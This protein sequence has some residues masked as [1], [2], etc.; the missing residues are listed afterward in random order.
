MQLRITLNKCTD[1]LVMPQ[2]RCTRYNADL[3]GDFFLLKQMQER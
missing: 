3:N 1:K 2:Q